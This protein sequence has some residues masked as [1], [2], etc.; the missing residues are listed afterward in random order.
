MEHSVLDN[1]EVTYSITFLQESQEQL[2]EGSTCLPHVTS[3]RI[4]PSFSELSFTIYRMPL[5][6]IKEV[7]QAQQLKQYYS[8][9]LQEIHER[10]TSRISSF[11]LR[12]VSIVLYKAEVVIL[13]FLNTNY[14][15]IISL[16][17]KDPY[18]LDKRIM[19]TLDFKTSTY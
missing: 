8:H 3:C 18:T 15:L 17:I 19:K 1:T 11:Y 10:T 14:E 7:L 12:G 2:R 9:H 13:P 4:D 6:L 5:H 16:I